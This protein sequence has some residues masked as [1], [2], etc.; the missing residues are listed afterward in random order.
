MS[1][2]NG[3]TRISAALH[4]GQG[5][6]STKTSE[7]MTTCLSSVDSSKATI[8]ADISDQLHAV[9]K[10]EAILPHVPLCKS[11]SNA[12]R[13]LEFFDDGGLAG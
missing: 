11:G 13:Q 2:E 7:I 5:R 8:K 1:S 4:F 9:P 10:N 6:G 12:T 3:S